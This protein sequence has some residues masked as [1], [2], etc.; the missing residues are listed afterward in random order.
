MGTHGGR[1]FAIRTGG[2][3]VAP[4]DPWPQFKGG[5]LRRG[6]ACGEQD[7]TCATGPEASLERCNGLDDDADGQVDEGAACPSCGFGTCTDTATAQARCEGDRCVRTCA[8]GF[9]GAEC[10]RPL[11]VTGDQPGSVAWVVSSE[12]AVRG[13]AA[14]DPGDGAVF[15]GSADFRM[16]RIERGG[17]E[18]CPF[19]SLY[20]IQGEPLVTPDG[21]AWFGGE[22]QHLYGIDR[23]CEQVCALPLLGFAQGG[24]ITGRPALLDDGRLVFGSGDG[25]FYT[26]DPERC[27]AERVAD[28]GGTIYGGPLVLSEQVFQGS[29][30][31]ALVAFDATTWTERWRATGPRSTARRRPHPMERP[32]TSPGEMAPCGPSR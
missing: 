32:S 20:G 30:S 14:V 7:W 29:Y 13:T 22:D 12:D 4:S 31:G 9:G 11:P 21:V 19:R 8:P 1:F 5:P 24:N 26:V 27:E 16:R 3:G 18:R 15:V 25:A 2:P 6:H 10:T 28:L 17:V 23:S